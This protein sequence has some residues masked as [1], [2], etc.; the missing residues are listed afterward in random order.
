MFPKVSD[1]VRGYV[2]A[3]F[4][5]KFSYKKIIEML[6]YRNVKI[7]TFA[8]H[9]II[10]NTQNNSLNKIST[11]SKQ[12][13]APKRSADTIKKVFKMVSKENPNTI[14]NISNKLNISLGT[15][16]NIIHKNLNLSKRKKGKVHKL[17]A[18]QRQQRKTSCRLLYEGYL[19]KDRWKNIVS[20]D[21]AWFY[22]TDCNKKR[23]IY[24][25]EKGKM[26]AH[27]QKPYTE[28]RESFAKGFMV[29]AGFCYKGKLRLRKVATKVKIN[30]DYYQKN[31]LKPIFHKEIPFLYNNDI[32]N[33][34]FHQ[35]KASSHFSKSTLCY[36]DKLKDETGINYI[37]KSHIPT[38]SPDASPMDFC[39]FGL[40]KRAVANRRAHTLNGLWKVL[41]EEWDR[42]SLPILQ[43]S[44]LSW[45]YR[46][47]SIVKNQG[48]PIEHNKVNKY[49]LLK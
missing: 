8:I 47:R 42:I 45:K 41:Q 36:L 37:P 40:L 3:L 12:H 29:V 38:K 20:I 16:H 19:A 26:D 34:H 18:M 27:A 35:D 13:I 2:I 48:H 28:R 21:E 9:K 25:K 5:A 14:R 6:K 32:S 22:V 17:T 33:V 46:C 1:V 10:K 44:L 24:Y 4:D 30:S 31:V 15:V 43:K 11:P 49:G 7:S 39:A 23:S